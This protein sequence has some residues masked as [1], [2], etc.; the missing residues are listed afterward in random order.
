[1]LIPSQPVLL[2]TEI[3]SS[4]LVPRLFPKTGYLLGYPEPAL[5]Q[6]TEERERENLVSLNP[7]HGTHLLAFTMFYSHVTNC[8]TFYGFASI[9]CDELIRTRQSRHALDE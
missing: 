9:N 7:L 1:M 3:M 2:S 5:Q 6:K 8:Y 4:N